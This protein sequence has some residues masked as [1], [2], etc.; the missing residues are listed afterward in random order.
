[1]MRWCDNAE[2]CCG[3]AGGKTYYVRSTSLTRTL[4]EVCGYYRRT[5]LGSVMR[6]DEGRPKC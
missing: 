6:N 1:M 3:K 2:I 4:L 5:A